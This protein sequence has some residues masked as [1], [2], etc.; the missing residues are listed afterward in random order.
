MD[1]QMLFNHTK[2][3]Q[4]DAISPI[5]ATLLLILIAIAAGVVVYAYVL[6][7][8]GG[9]TTN[10]GGSTSVIQVSAFC[11]SASTNCNGGSMYVTLTNVGSTSVTLSTSGAGQLY[12]TDITKGTTTAIACPA[13]S[14]TTV[15]ANG[16]TGSVTIT[17]NNSYTCSIAAS[18]YLTGAT[19]LNSAIGDTMSI[20][21]VNPDS[22]SATQTT[23]LIS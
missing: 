8:I 1:R 16:G 12:F 4:R 7:F 23:K 15:N 10:P 11:M 14:P 21:V 3:Q 2:R 19:L 5:I 17:P 6:G 9:A 13:T 18:G 20:K 22:G